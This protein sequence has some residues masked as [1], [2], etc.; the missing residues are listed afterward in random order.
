MVRSRVIVM[1]AWTFIIVGGGLTRVRPAVAQPE[2]C[3][4]LESVAPFTPWAERVL[5]TEGLPRGMTAVDI[6]ADSDADVLTLHGETSF[7]EEGVLRVHRNTCVGDY[8]E[9]AEAYEVPNDPIQLFAADL[10]GDERPEVAIISGSSF[11]ETPFTLR[12]Y[13]NDGEGNFEDPQDFSLGTIGGAGPRSVFAADLDEDSDREVICCGNNQSGQFVAIAWNRWDEVTND[14]DLQIYDLTNT[15]APLIVTCADMDQQDGVDVIVGAQQSAFPPS[16]IA[17]VFLNQG[18]DAGGSHS[19]RFV[20]NA[21][22]DDSLGGLGP[23]AGSLAAGAFNDDSYPDLA[24][25]ARTATST[26]MMLS[27]SLTRC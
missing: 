4:P 26:S 19:T 6:E 27:A 16:G 2:G 23:P 15:N 25:C 1:T 21:A 17:Y 22:A 12:I 7:A 14:F 9:A 20:F 13:I 10:T 24:W 8:F 5:E 18:G 11:Y 3:E